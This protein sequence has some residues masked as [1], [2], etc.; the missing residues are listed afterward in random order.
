MERL[1]FKP[2][3]A[4]ATSLSIAAVVMLL[5]LG[6]EDAHLPVQPT[7]SRPE[8]T[9]QAAFSLSGEV[10]DIAGRPLGG[11]RVEVTSGPRA[12][13]VT[14]T[15][16]AGQFLMPGTFT[17]AIAVT[18]S[19]SGYGSATKLFT[20]F[21]RHTFELEPLVPG[22]NIAGTYT[23]TFDADDVCTNLPDEV[24]TRTYTATIIPGGR[25]SLFAAGLSGGRFF[26]GAYGL[27]IGV[28]GD[29][30][31]I[32]VGIIEQ[33]SD[34]TYFM[35]EGR[36]GGTFN[37]TGVTIPLNGA[38]EYCASQPT[39]V[40]QGTWACLAKPAIRCDSLNHHLTLLRH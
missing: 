31:G 4:I 15:D 13:A 29:Y 24:R 14:T 33:L 8:S 30:A 35:I 7:P 10:Y 5:C 22:V 32:Y 23:L 36:A 12:G 17:G 1:N 37:P 21:V 26:I 25:S 27:R 18:V 9:A 34:T 6:C 2:R 3:R 39:Q 40:D 16:E 28:V 20:E 11:S 19:K 38:V